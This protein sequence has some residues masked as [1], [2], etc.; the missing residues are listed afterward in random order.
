M[1]KSKKADDP[2]TLARM[3]LARHEGVIARLVGH[4]GLDVHLMGRDF[5][6]DVRLD[7][8]DKWLTEEEAKEVDPF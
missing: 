1:A 6:Q 8:L 7:A 5:I 3:S 2:L 4:L